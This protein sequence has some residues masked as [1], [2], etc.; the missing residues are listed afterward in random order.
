[1]RP[2]K[3]LNGLRAG[4]H[5][6]PAEVDDLE[7]VVYLWHEM[8]E[9]HIEHDAAF[10]LKEDAV[11]AYRPYAQSL[12]ENGAKLT[13]VAEEDCEIEGYIFG[14][15]VSPPPVHPGRKWG[16]VNEISVSET[17]RNMGLG[18]ELLHEAERW[19]FKNDVE[20]IECRVAVTNPVSQRFWKK[21]GYAGY[22]EVCMKEL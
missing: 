1:M 12:I 4:I 17:H 6:R 3:N 10:T 2:P 18:T 15:I 21:H 19:F 7:A 14:E 9:F 22:I 13:L 8:M 5:I 20:R 16:F 11:D